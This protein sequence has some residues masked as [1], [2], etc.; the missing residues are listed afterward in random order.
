MK[1]K[2]KLDNNAIKKN[3][4]DTTLIF[5]EF[6]EPSKLKPK[7]TIDDMDKNR[8]APPVKS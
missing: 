2:I 4:P 7:A 3:I 5:A 1:V 8:K 6:L